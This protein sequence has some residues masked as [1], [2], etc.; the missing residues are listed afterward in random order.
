VVEPDN[1]DM[2]T[3]IA[4][5][6]V[7]SLQ[8]L[9]GRDPALVAAVD[10]AVRMAP[11]RAPVL[12]M[13]ESGT[14]K[15][16][17]ARLLHDLG[18]NPAGPLVAVNCGALSRELAES[19]LFGHERGAFTGAAGRR[20]G[21]F[22]EASGGTLVLDEIGELPLELQPKLLRVLET[23]RLRRVGGN[24]ETSVRVRVVAVT[25]RD[26]RE[27]VA[28]GSFR[29]DLY[30]RLSAFELTLPPLR[31]RPS[32]I[33][34]LAHRFLDELA[35]EVGPRQLTEAAC[36]RLEA[37]RWPGNVRELRN[38]IRRAAFLCEGPID[39]AN[40]EL[41]EPPI[42]LQPANRPELPRPGDRALRAAE[43]GGP[44]DRPPLGCSPTCPV[45]TG[46]ALLLT[47]RKFVDL[48]KEIYRWALRENGGSR[49]RAAKA[50]GISRSTFCDRVKR[51]AL[52]PKEGKEGKED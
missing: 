47:G 48:E 32:D 43:P 49:R 31:D 6:P 25:L 27:E 30:H 23:G 39:A 14:G 38:V 8:A 5:S 22:E 33:L 17:L 46:A 2:L 28:R 12:V 11:A 7:P 21:W 44:G 40:L 50:L 42:Q 15:E 26:L 18:P 16:L 9:V 41:G 20:V 10:R 35:D 36:R 45:T 34:L 24:G 29:T 37:H 1:R 52:S 4:S 13:G 3:A 51:L 19:E